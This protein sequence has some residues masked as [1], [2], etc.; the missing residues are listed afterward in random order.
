M[1]PL[2]GSGCRDRGF[3]GKGVL[4]NALFVRGLIVAAA[5]LVLDQ[6]SKWVI[7]NWVMAPPRTIALTPFF[8]LVLS[9]NTGISFGLFGGGPEAG[10]WLFIGLGCVIIAV[11]LVWMARSTR[12]LLV[13]AIGLI[14]GG[15]V[16]NIVDRLRF[17]AV[18][19][20]LYFHYR[21]YGFPAFNLAD[22]AISIGVALILIDSLFVDRRSR[23]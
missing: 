7:L 18:A 11:L 15:A 19:D 21:E 17:G 10:R 16:G 3:G 13:F 14:V 2:C 12:G 6:L 20:F 9:W 4:M 8:D 5:V 1:Q 22:S 23:K